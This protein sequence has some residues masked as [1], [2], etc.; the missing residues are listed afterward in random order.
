MGHCSSASLWAGVEL[1]SSW[2]GI[3]MLHSRPQ[4][5]KGDD[6]GNM[7]RQKA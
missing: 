3:P 2:E 1:V 6:D 7:S 4:V 5:R